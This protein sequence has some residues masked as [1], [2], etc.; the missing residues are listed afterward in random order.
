ML[1]IPP[2]LILNFKQLN[3][4]TIFLLRSFYMIFFKLQQH[5]IK[6]KN[7]T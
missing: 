5:F 1:Q 6:K 2:E 4:A 7:L 3:Y